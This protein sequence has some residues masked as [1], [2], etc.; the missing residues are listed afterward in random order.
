MLHRYSRSLQQDLPPPYAPPYLAVCVW[1]GVGADA[2]DTQWVEIRDVAEY[3]T[4]TST[5]K[6]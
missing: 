3:P 4:V 6:N 5:T 1:G 2:T